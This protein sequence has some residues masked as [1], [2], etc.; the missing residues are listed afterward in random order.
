MAG[1]IA[2]VEAFKLAERLREFPDSMLLNRRERTALDGGLGAGDD[3]DEDRD[4]FEASRTYP[5]RA[6]TSHNSRSAGHIG[7][8]R[9]NIFGALALG[10]GNRVLKEVRCLPL[11]LVPPNYQL[12]L[13]LET[14]S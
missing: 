8:G 12:Q 2:T 11:G 5:Y 13:K 7:T 10:R 6:G 1:V 14:I 9:T 4:D 3:F